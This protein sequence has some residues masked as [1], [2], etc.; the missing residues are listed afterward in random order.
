MPGDWGFR[1]LNLLE[2]AEAPTVNNERKESRGAHSRDDYPERD[3]K[4]W[5]KHSIYFKDSK[6]TKRDVNFRLGVQA[7]QCLQGPI[8]EYYRVEQ[9]STLKWD[10]LWFWYGK[11]PYM[12]KLMSIF[13]KIKILCIRCLHSKRTGLF[14]LFQR[15]CREGVCGSD[16]MNINGKNGLGCITHFRK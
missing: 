14:N 7:F 15:S 8:N 9:I 4:N 5:L 11:K 2:V 16:G 1:T 13:Q 6:V 10:Q 12:Q 3:D